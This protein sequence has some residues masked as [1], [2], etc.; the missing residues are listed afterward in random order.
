MAKKRS[1]FKTVGFFLAI[2]SGEVCSDTPAVQVVL[3]QDGRSPGIALAG[4]GLLLTFLTGAW[5]SAA[6]F[7][8]GKA[9]QGLVNFFDGKLKTSGKLE[10][11]SIHFI[12]T[13]GAFAFH[14]QGI[15]QDDLGHAKSGYFVGNLVEPLGEFGRG[16]GRKGEGEAEFVGMAQPNPL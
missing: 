15:A 13:L 10:G 12:A 9:G 2:G 4:A 5:L 11:E 3:Q 14:G 1:S 16:R 6:H 7:I 8:G